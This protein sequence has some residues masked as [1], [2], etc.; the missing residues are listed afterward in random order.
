MPAPPEMEARQQECTSESVRTMYTWIPITI[1]AGAGTWLAADKLFP[2]FRRFNFRPKL[3]GV[4]MFVI[5]FSYHRAEVA[6]L[7]CR[8]RQMEQ[9]Q[10]EKRVAKQEAHQKIREQRAAF[11]ASQ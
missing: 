1:A 11:E 6:M 5:A 2:K 3:A 10:T 7:A 4:C 9:L 8:M